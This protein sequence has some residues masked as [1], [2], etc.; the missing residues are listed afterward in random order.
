MPVYKDLRILQIVSADGWYSEFEVSQDITE[1]DP[2]ACW[3][4]FEFK[5]ANGE[6]V[7]FLD[8]ID[9][10][11]GCNGE[12]VSNVENFVR[13]IHVCQMSDEDKQRITSR[14]NMLPFP[15]QPKSEAD[16]P[17]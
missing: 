2:L 15:P 13:Y 11:P 7:T 5:E 6:K 3:G 10:A 4:L 12:P 16:V 17:G 1:F 14:G 8:G 9:P